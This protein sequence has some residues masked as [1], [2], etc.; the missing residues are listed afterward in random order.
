M[1]DYYLP[2]NKVFLPSTHEVVQTKRNVITVLGASVAHSVA[3]QSQNLKVVSS[4]LTISNRFMPSNLG[5]ARRGVF[6]MWDNYLPLNTV[7][8]LCSHEIVQTKRKIIT[9]LVEK[10]SVL[11]V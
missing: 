6:L 9:I 8:L 5:P 3:H 10:R 7:L 4:S 1:F 2:F 11:Y